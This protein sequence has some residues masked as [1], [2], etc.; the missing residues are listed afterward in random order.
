MCAGN[1]VLLEG[2]CPI[3]DCREKPLILMTDSPAD[4]GCIACVGG[5]GTLGCLKCIEGSPLWVSM[6]EQMS[7][8]QPQIV[9]SL[10]SQ[11]CSVPKNPPPIYQI[12]SS[13]QPT[14]TNTGT[15][16]GPTLTTA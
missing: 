13:I 7:T 8:L 1:F 6:M 2:S 9:A 10:Q 12:G 14:L 16:P 11:Y 15:A 4:P 3:L 5:L